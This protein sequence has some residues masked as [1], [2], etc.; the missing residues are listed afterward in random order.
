[1]ADLSPDEI[2]AAQQLA[3]QKS[4]TRSQH[5]PPPYDPEAVTGDFW[6]AAGDVIARR[7]GS[8]MEFAD[9]VIVHRTIAEY[10]RCFPQ[11]AQRIQDALLQAF[12]G[13]HVLRQQY[14]RSAEEPFVL[15]PVGADAQRV[16]DVEARVRAA[17][18]DAARSLVTA[19]RRQ[20]PTSPDVAEPANANDVQG[21]WLVIVPMFQLEVSDDPPVNGR[22]DVGDVA[23]VSRAKLATILQPP[24]L[25]NLP[26]PNA[27]EKIT[28]DDA[29]FAVIKLTGTPNQL[30]RTMFRELR[31]AANILAAT[32][33]FYGKRH[34]VSGFTLKGYP[35]FTAKNDRFIQTDGTAFCGNWNQRGF[36]HPFTLDANWHRAISDT[37]I[38]DLF[39]RINDTADATW[40]RQ[41]R[42][43]AAML[44]RSLMSLDLA[45]A[46]LLNV[47]GLETLLTKPRE[48]NGPKMFKRIKG[49]TGWHLRTARRNYEAEINNIHGVRCEI[50]H[51]SD[52][53]NL[54]VELLLQ[55]DLYL[56]NSLLN[57]VRLPAVFPDK[58]TLV[59]TL[60]GYATNENWP[61]DGSL[62]FRWLGNPY[63]SQADLDLPL[64]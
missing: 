48:R 37:G 38:I 44:G 51:D 34:H 24:T 41:I 21:T 61:T 25:T 52:Y 46:F 16:G 26:R 54:T 45:D 35:A 18:D 22:W 3:Y 47:I 55:S 12:P 59:T 31:E 20:P 10:G 19:P 17:Y 8:T 2:A 33:G 29:S 28:G 63:F 11:Y 7:P 39:A 30:R 14:Q 42:S 36:L 58:A 4:L 27:W 1:M 23:F 9:W 62:P 50:V 40:R 43:G 5:S 57:I 53:S 49:M 6:Q 64:W 60:D 56:T 15:P 13:A 32:A